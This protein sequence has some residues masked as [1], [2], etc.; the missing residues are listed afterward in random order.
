MLALYFAA[1]YFEFFGPDF[2]L[3]PDTRRTEVKNQNTVE[4]LAKVKQHPA[5]RPF[6]IAP[7]SGIGVVQPLIS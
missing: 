1:D 7:S 4:Y 6:F 3:H 2:K 5:A